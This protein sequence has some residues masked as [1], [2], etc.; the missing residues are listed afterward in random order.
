[1]RN[2]HC[3]PGGIGSIFQGAKQKDGD[4]HVT[5]FNA[6]AEMW[7][8]EEAFHDL[9]LNDCGQRNVSVRRYAAL[10]ILLRGSVPPARTEWACS[11]S[12]GFRDKAECFPATP[13]P[14]SVSH[15]PLQFDFLYTV[16]PTGY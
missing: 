6:T 2:C 14:Y 10:A 12:F 3:N 11:P 8:N 4:F 15:H 13:S 9:A 16:I 5:E 1:M 7:N